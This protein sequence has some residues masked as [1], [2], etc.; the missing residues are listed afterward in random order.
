[1]KLL[2]ICM[3]AIMAEYRVS[4]TVNGVGEDQVQND[5]NAI[6]SSCLWPDDNEFMRKLAWAQSRYG[7]NYIEPSGNNIYMVALVFIL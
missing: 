1:M 6:H 3:V 4:A 5:L 7:K 2:L